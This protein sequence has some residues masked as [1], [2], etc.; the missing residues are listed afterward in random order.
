M[1]KIN[2][3]LLILLAP[4]FALVSCK[5]DDELKHTRVSP[6]EALYAPDDNVFLNLGADSQV[7][8]E[9]QA[10]R[11]EDNGV[12][13]YEVVFASEDGDFTQPVYAIP[14]DGNG[15]QRRLTL[16]FS[17]LN[18]IAGMAGIPTDAIGKLKWSVVSSKGINV[19]EAKTSRII[20]VQR[21]AGFPPPD[22]LFIT[23]SATEGGEAIENGL[24]FKKIGTSE[25]EI[26]TKLVPGEY[27]FAT[28]KTGTPDLYSI[29]DGKLVEGG[30]TTVTEEAVYRIRL[31]FSTATTNIAKVE[32]LSLWFAPNG[33]FLFDIP[34]AGNGTW[35]IENAAI[36]FKQ[37]DWGRDERYKFRFVVDKGG[38]VVD[39]W[40][41]SVNSDNSRPNSNTGGSY[42]HMV[43]V[44]G[45]R[46]NNCFKFA[47]QVDENESDIEVIF[48]ASVPAYTHVVTP[49]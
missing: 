16:P 17:V 39:E 37:E 13:L 38:D 8:F 12:V 34:Y 20:E 29:A 35:K 11:A 46:W 31:D 23:G 1:K 19:T 4:V 15:L 41:G 47:D 30:A 6:V 40:Y 33:T 28:R 32:T 21:P 14:S 26:H 10:A 9:W 18:T 2:F 27:Q 49:H 36:E 22:E 24:L 42:W 43:P 48:N 7:I 5:D 25:F 45:D 3:L 44:D